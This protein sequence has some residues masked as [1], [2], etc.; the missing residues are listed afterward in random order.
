MTKRSCG[1]D[2][3]KVVNKIILNRKGT[4]VEMSPLVITLIVVV[5]VLLVLVGVVI[6]A[7]SSLVVL[8]NRVERRHGATLLFS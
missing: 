6:G 4:K 8:R 7:Y 2:Y 3:H 1:F 5:V